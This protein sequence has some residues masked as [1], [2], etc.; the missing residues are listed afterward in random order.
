MTVNTTT[1]LSL[2]NS[3]ASCHWLRPLLLNVQAERPGYLSCTFPTTVWRYYVLPLSFFLTMQLQCV[4]HVLAP[5]FLLMYIHNIWAMTSDC[6]PGL[7]FSIPGSRHPVGIG[8]VVKTTKIA[9]WV[10]PLRYSGSYFWRT[11][12]VRSCYGFSACCKPYRNILLQL[13]LS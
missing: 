3:V 4:R 5:S 13:L 7:E 11:R 10:T 12:C 8:V 2:D 1:V 6:N 9:T